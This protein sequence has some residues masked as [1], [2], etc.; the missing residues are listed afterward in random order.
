MRFYLELTNFRDEKKRYIIFGDTT[1]DAFTKTTKITCQKAFVS[2]ALRE[3]VKKNKDPKTSRLTE[4]TARKE[5]SE[6]S[7]STE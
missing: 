1:T 4:N 7:G 6:S 5:E 2:T 3:I